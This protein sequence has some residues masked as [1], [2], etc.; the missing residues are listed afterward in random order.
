MFRIKILLL[1]VV[2]L[3]LNKVLSQSI[4]VGDTTCNHV[5]LDTVIEIVNPGFFGSWN[6]NSSYGIDC[7]QDMVNDMVFTKTAT[8]FNGGSGSWSNI[9]LSCSNVSG[10]EFVHK[11]TT[12]SCNSGTVTLI[13]SLTPSL[14]L[15]SSLNW[16]SAL[17]S[18]IYEV[19]YQMGGMA[20]GAYHPLF[21]TRAYL[22][23][24]KILTNDTIY[25]WIRLNTNSAYGYR[26]DEI[27]SIAY[28]HTSANNT[29][30]PVFTSTI[31]QVCLG[32]SLA[33][34]GNPPGGIFNGTGVSGN[35]FN[36]LYTGAG[37]HNVFY[38]NGCTLP[39][40][41]SIT[42]HPPPAIAFTNT[43]TAVCLGY[44][45]GLSASPPG[46]T[47]SGPGVIGNAFSSFSTGTSSVN[48]S[49]TD[50]YGCS[51][52]T[53]L[54]ISTVTAPVL[55]AVSSSTQ[56]CPAESVTISVSGA[57]N[58]TWSTGAQTSSIVV[59]PTAITVYTVTGGFSS[60]TCPMSTISFTQV[61]GNP[62]ITLSAPTI[63]YCP[64]YSA[65]IF[66]SGATN[67]TW[68]TGS[69]SYWISSNPTVTTTYS[70]TGM[71]SGGC[72]DT[73]YHTVNVAALPI[74]NVTSSQNVACS[75]D[76]LV[77]YVNGGFSNYEIRDS[78]NGQWI[79][80][81]ASPSVVVNPTANITYCL[82]V[83]YNGPNNCFF[84]TYFHQKVVSCVGIKEVNREQNL[85]RIFPNPN[86]GE[87]EIKGSKE[88]EVYVRNELGQTV[89]NLQLNNHNNFSVKVNDLE[90][91]I[92]FVGDK[93]NTQKI[94]IIR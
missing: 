16:S 34:T 92:Y 67:Y 89:R 88:I 10:I 42:V 85:L 37:V 49:Y 55:N 18:M 2:L 38:S 74:V 62:T 39:A 65:A 91:G 24:R 13:D 78:V 26:K 58:Y 52:T 87:F 73:A 20:C 25:G 19:Y 21:K 61:A 45:L 43:Q 77:I 54:S 12:T 5:R 1:I 69:T 23:F 35:V 6:A 66:A 31:N 84:D 57:S 71:N 60:G 30:T 70:V 81:S 68:S 28:K 47:F 48:Y 79:T 33:L 90:N 50:T 76:P 11:N 44:S 63:S 36:S 80:A 53:T 17:P 46:G 82:R 56:S 27:V 64:G 94:V 7:D 4:F 40:V 59:T 41:K 15:N 72:S 75:G 9:K 83:Y 86:S 29:V 51:N 32:G 93:F 8:G 22:G 3:S 14:P